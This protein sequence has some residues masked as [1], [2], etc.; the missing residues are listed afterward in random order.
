MRQ[1]LFPDTMLDLMPHCISASDLRVCLC[2]CLAQTDERDLLAVSM[3]CTMLSISL[4]P[5]EEEAVVSLVE[6]ALYL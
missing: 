2:G 3:R 1:S 5:W 6:V 4:L